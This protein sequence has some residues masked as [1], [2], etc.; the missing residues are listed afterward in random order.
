MNPLTKL[1]FTETKL[2]FREPIGVFF[3]LAFPP[4]LLVILG[5]IPSFR[6]PN[7]DLHGARTIDL[8]APIVIAMSIALLAFNGLPQI[9]ATY[10][11]KGI[12]RRMATTPVRPVVV[13]AAQLLMCAAMSLV[14]VILVQ[15]VG[16]I[17]FAVPLP[18]QAGGY[19]LAYLLTVVTALTIGLLIAALAPS[20]KGA[21]S[22]GTLLF[23][24][25]LFFAG[26]WL[27]RASMPEVL[28][29]ISDF[30]PLGAGV[31]SLQDAANG[32]WPQPLHIAVML[33]WTVA[34]GAVA[35]RNFRWE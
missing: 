5:S 18:R 10:R 35:A 33:V 8:Y 29:R 20:G 31:Q 27:P 22:I 17:V 4:L 11:E 16:R 32:G 19:V 21:G 12:L 25:V 1:T 9:L 26:L 3:T 13:L 2:F 7:Q 24:P 15:T 34:A 14:A 28:R 30:T 23:F 6:E